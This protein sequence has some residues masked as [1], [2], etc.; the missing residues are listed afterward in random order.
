[1]SAVGG[2]P[3]SLYILS[4]LVDR[5]RL[6]TTN[7]VMTTNP[8]I[9]PRE[10]RDLVRGQ[11]GL[12]INKHSLG[13]RRLDPLRSNYLFFVFFSLEDITIGCRSPSKDRLI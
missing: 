1:M 4:E 9:N 7:P 10:E 5:K 2:V 6:F 3:L 13:P 12:V 8:A 11:A